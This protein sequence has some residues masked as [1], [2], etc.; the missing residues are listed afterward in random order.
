VEGCV[1]KASIQ[2]AQVLSV[3]VFPQIAIINAA[4]NAEMLK[5]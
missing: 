5:C 3:E 4:R 2:I 1:S